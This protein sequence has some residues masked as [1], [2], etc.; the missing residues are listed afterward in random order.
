MKFEEVKQPV[1]PSKTM[2]PERATAKSGGHDFRIKETIEIHP[3]EVKTTWTDV[4]VKINGRYTLD[5]YPRSSIGIKK[6]VIL[7]NTVGIIDADY[8]N[9]PDN[10]GNIGIALTNQGDKTI[11][12]EAG[13]R[14]AQGIFRRYYVTEDDAADGERVGGFGSTDLKEMKRLSDNIQREMFKPSI[15]NLAEEIRDRINNDKW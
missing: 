14:V 1:H 8:Y 2:L 3:G 11:M 15:D 7:A 13:E 12:L 10:D 5:V 6:R 4:K 9:N